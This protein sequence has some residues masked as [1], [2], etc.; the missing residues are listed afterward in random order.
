MGLKLRRGRGPSPGAMGLQ[1][2]PSAMITIRFTAR[3]PSRGIRGTGGACYLGPCLLLAA[4][5]SLLLTCAATSMPAGAR[6]VD[7]AGD[8]RAGPDPQ[9]V[10]GRAGVW[11]RDAASQELPVSH[12]PERDPSDHDIDHSD[13]GAIPTRHVSGRHIDFAAILPQ[14]LSSFGGEAGALRSSAPSPLSLRPSAA[15]GRARLRAARPPIARLL[16]RGA[17][18][19]GHGPIH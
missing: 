19:H 13:G 18:S 14:T 10:A 1:G 3:Q 9:R 15:A 8:R 5:L 4:S 17:A 2:S 11:A 6:A 7:G 16:R 12:A